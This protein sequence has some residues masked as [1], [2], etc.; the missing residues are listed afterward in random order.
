M[1]TGVLLH[2]RSAPSL[3]GTT[4]LFDGLITAD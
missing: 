4:D 3:T 1:S 2:P